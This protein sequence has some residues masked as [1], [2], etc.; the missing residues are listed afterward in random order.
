VNDRNSDSELFQKVYKELC[1]DEISMSFVNAL[2]WITA[3]SNKT[4][5]KLRKI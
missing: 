2:R 4:L 3:R 5:L 1:R